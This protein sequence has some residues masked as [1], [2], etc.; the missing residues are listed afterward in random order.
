MAD[1][2]GIPS[3]VRT[4]VRERAGHHCEYCQSQDRFSSSP[5]VVEHIEPKA[6][7]G[8]TVLENLAYA[9]AGCNGHKATKSAAPDPLTGEMVGLFHPRR[10]LWREHF[11]WDESATVIE[12]LTAEGRATVV[13]LQLNR[14]SLVNMRRVLRRSGDHPPDLGADGTS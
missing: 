7:G 12:G 9:C 2:R 10:Q 3:A 11:A 14:L 1:K 6:S 8:T 4:V 5:F 13:A